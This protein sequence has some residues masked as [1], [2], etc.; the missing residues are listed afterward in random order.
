M[1]DK[2]E[3]L[4]SLYRASASNKKLDL[5]RL[6]EDYQGAKESQV[7]GAQALRDY[8]HKLAGSAGMYGFDDLHVAAKEAL[9]AV[10]TSYEN[11][12]SSASARIGERVDVGLI[13]TVIEE[14]DALIGADD[15]VN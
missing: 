2:I 8:L 1:V 13:L 14:L 4:K 9:S 11:S 6:L 10:E 12:K 15:A 5:S 7:E 3:E